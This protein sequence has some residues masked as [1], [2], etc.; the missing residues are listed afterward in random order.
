MQRAILPAAFLLLFLSS[1]C[2]QEMSAEN[3]LRCLD[4]T[5][6]GYAFVPE[7][8]TQ[9]E[10]FSLIEMGLFGFDAAVF[11][12]GVQ[13]E[14]YH[15]K[16][17]A[18]LSWLYFNKARANISEIHSI[19]DSR[20]NIQALPDRLNLLMH[21]LQKAFEFSDSAS[22]RSFSILL[23]EESDLESEEISLMK[24][25]PLF[26]DFILISSNLN[27]L[28]SG[29]CSGQSY[30]CFYLTQSAE[31]QSLASSTGFGVNLV[32]EVGALDLLES[33]KAEAGSYAEASFSIPFLS[34]V[35]PPLI[36]YFNSF[37]KVSEAVSRL[38]SFPAFPFLQSYSQFMGENNS[39]L[40]KFS[41]VLKSDSLHR[42]DLEQRNAEL[43]NQVPEKLAAASQSLGSLLS[44]HYASFDA[45]FFQGLYS[46]LGQASTVSSQKYSIQDLSE[47]RQE[48]IQ[49]LN[50]LR[51]RFI[52][53]SQ[54]D[55]LSQVS[56][57]SR[58]SA[59]KE[60]NYEAD[61]LLENLAYLNSEALD[62]L[63]VLC[64][65]RLS[66][67][68][69]RLNEA[70]LPESNFLQ[71]ADLR[72][73]AIFKLKQFQSAEET[74]QRLFYCREAVEE[75]S[76]FELSLQ[77]F[78]E[79][80][81]QEQLSLG[82]CL[83][84]LEKVLGSSQSSIDFDGFIM[85]FHSL[86]SIPK[87]Y[88]DIAA[89]ER[90]CSTLK[91][92]LGQ[93]LAEH[94]LLKG[95]LEK[96]SS[97]EHLLNAMQLLNSMDKSVLPDSKIQSLESGFKDFE[98]FFSNGEIVFEQALPV[99]PELQDSLSEFSSSL[100]ETA[101]TSIASFAEKNALLSFE[102]LPSG[103]ELVGVSFRN[104]FAEIP[105]PLTLTL[106]F[107]QPLGSVLSSS[108]NVS[109]ARQSNNKIFF[110]LSSFPLGE[111]RASFSTS[112]LYSLKESLEILS[113]NSGQAL[114]QKTLDIECLQALPSLQLRAKLIDSNALSFS[115]VQVYSSGKSLAFSQNNSEISFSLEN[116]FQGETAKILF[117]VE[118]PI[119]IRS[120]LLRSTVQ[121]DNK[122]MYTY[123]ILI[124]NRLPLPLNSVDLILPIELDETAIEGIELLDFE[125]KKLKFSALP[126]GKIAFSLTGLLPLQQ[127]QPLFLAVLVHET[128]QP[129]L[130]EETPSDANSGSGLSVLGEKIE[131]ISQ[132]IGFLEGIFSPV[133]EQDLIEARY[134]PPFTEQE[135][136]SLKLKLS[137]L[138]SS[139]EK[140]Y[141]PEML[142]E[143]ESLSL[144]LSAATNAIKEDALAAFNSAVEFINSSPHNEDAASALK[145]AESALNRKSYLEAVALSRK[146]VSLASLQQQTPL[147]FDFPIFL[148]PIAIAAGLVFLA[149]K[150]KER[151][152]E[153]Q[154][155][156]V[157]K[158]AR[159]W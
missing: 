149:R 136:N 22:R 15:Y 83:S 67:A 143:A 82:E 131:G 35:I 27:G 49:K 28:S 156:L 7:C 106:D 12:S 8:K 89:V 158:I 20:A 59:L 148:F 81:L 17:D 86:K 134:V 109:G 23:L 119:Q 92:S 93:Y 37:T 108:E 29:A 123:E 132:G 127:T 32:A 104:L 36:S 95:L 137:R 159:N 142:S 124:T 13:S 100:G 155:Q 91:G 128:A 39:A 85:R 74:G 101:L 150:R 98:K 99:L 157:K 73:R 126:N 11:S 30:A 122:V 141:S 79:Y 14:L 144:Q 80:Q 129:L 68:E 151:L 113:A 133:P 51:E 125:G 78:E 42:L 38:E 102:Q 25:E 19:C 31:F 65:E 55:Y 154:K 114:F 107:G 111:T 54:Q 58:T 147:Q 117:S 43:Q 90:N 64:N 10:C 45:N 116:C 146:A 112:R 103:T 76:K 115:N 4:L 52:G 97:S 94:A 138:R 1:G 18:A 72:A 34:K 46:G 33:Y 16:N 118:S 5:S 88:E 105:G 47:L 70:A 152:A 62:G 24:E 3:R 110:D 6:K 50:S 77:D 41:L 66:L 140:G 26:N 71:A 40:Q 2:I 87:P 48:G 145:Q 121:A 130:L 57:G 63:L 56:L 139:L 84:F 44:E 9:E 60:F 75:F 53:F 21:N 96:H 135:L 120:S 153:Q 69:K 61:L